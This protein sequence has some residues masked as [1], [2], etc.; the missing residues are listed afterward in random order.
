M[1]KSP[2]DFVKA[3]N[4]TKEYNFEDGDEAKFPGFVINMALSYHVDTILYANQM[5]LSP[6]LKP[7]M[8]YDYLF[9]S[10][11]QKKRFATWEKKIEADPN[12]KLIMQAYKYSYKRAKE[13]LSILTKEQL[14]IIQK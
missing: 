13:I 5:N 11:R 12:I 6:N 9:Y 10:I 3:I 8:M 4:Q 14:A 1:A 2:F 7:K